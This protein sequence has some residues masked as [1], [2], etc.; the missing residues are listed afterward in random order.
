MLA[1]LAAALERPVTRGAGRSSKRRASARRT[2][3]S[4]FELAPTT[5]VPG[6]LDQA[7]TILR[8]VLAKDPTNA[9]ALNYLGYM[10]ADHSRK[11]PE[12]LDLIKRAL[13]STRQ[14]VLSDSLGWGYLKLES[15]SARAAAR[16]GRSRAAAGVGDSGPPRPALLPAQAI[17]RRGRGLRS[18]LS[19][20]REGLVVTAVTKRRDRARELARK[21]WRA[22]RRRSE[23]LASAWRGFAAFRRARRGVRSADRPRRALS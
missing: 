14:P 8:N 17:P 9:E 22:G 10:L 12:A 19:G 15:S 23:G 3:G 2:T 16:A 1:D 18:A 7:E 13:R 21:S 4:Q 11:L 5:I 20:D 6:Q